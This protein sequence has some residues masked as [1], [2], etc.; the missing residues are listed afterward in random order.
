MPQISPRCWT[1]DVENRKWHKMTPPVLSYRIK[2]LRGL[3]P[4]LLEWLFFFFL[5]FFPPTFPFQSLWHVTTA[6]KNI[7]YFHVHAFSPRTRSVSGHTDTGLCRMSRNSAERIEH[8]SVWYQCT[9]KTE[10]FVQ[11]REICRIHFC[12]NFALFLNSGTF[13]IDYFIFIYIY[14]LQGHM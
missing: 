6:L 13:F 2:H 14:L 7:L 3:A 10:R 9:G 1:S 11:V 8:N 12:V 4:D 5:S